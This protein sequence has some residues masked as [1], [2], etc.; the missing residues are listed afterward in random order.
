MIENVLVGD[1]I[2]GAED[3]DDGDVVADVGEGGLDCTTALSRA[4][5]LASPA[6]ANET[7]TTRRGR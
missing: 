3:D 4:S 1:D 6:H 2:E 7:R 5:A